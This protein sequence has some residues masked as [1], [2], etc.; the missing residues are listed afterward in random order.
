MTT[1][2]T[3]QTVRAVV[4]EVLAQL[5]Q[6]NGV[7]PKANGSANQNG[8]DWGVFTDVDAA[9]AAANAAL[10]IWAPESAGLPEQ[11]QARPR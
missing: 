9:V 2:S 6:S 4:Q 7:A 8:G 11:I 1:V 3:E 10:R 5:T